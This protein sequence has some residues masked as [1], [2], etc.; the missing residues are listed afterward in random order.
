MVRCTL[1]QT[2]GRPPAAVFKAI[3]DL[4]TF[5]DWNPTTKAA[6]K[7]TDG[8]VGEGTRFELAVR[9]FGRTVQELRE[10]QADRQ[11]RLVPLSRS[12]T[13]GHRFVLRASGAST[14]VAHE[15]E[16][17]P[18]GLLRLMAPMLGPMMRKN[19]HATAAALKEYV[20]R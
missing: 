12:F 14:V 5:P 17:H 3:T 20:E 6:A 16:L 13:G 15:L 1:T 11:V 8:P 10:F 9:G 2:I 7:L 4:R 18:R 19:L